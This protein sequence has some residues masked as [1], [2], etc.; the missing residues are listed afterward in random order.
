MADVHNRIF[1]VTSGNNE[2]EFDILKAALNKDT[3]Q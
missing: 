2:F 3:L 1:Q